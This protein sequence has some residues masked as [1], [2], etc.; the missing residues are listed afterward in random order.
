MTTDNLAKWCM[1]Q[2]EMI[3]ALESNISTLIYSNIPLLEKYRQQCSIASIKEMEKSILISKF[4]LM[5][6]DIGANNFEKL[7]IHFKNKNYDQCHKYLEKYNI[8]YND[9]ETFFCVLKDFM[10]HKKKSQV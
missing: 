3:N 6:E 4:K 8:M 1:K 7:L 2:S 9:M 5:I 10:H